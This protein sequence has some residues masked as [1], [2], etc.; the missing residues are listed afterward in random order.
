MEMQTPSIFIEDLLPLNP[1]KFSEYKWIWMAD[2]AVQK[3][4]LKDR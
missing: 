3:E 1:T 2:V 4:A